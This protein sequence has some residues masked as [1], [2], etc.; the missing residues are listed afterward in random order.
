MKVELQYQVK[1]NF[2]N[3]SNTFMSFQWIWVSIS[4][5]DVAEMVTKQA[6]NSAEYQVIF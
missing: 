5:M 1:L 6:I 3:L 2:R 4:G